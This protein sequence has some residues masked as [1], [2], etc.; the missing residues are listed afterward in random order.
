MGNGT[1][2]GIE[3]LMVSDY[4]FLISYLIK[5]QE[6]SGTG[7]QNIPER[8]GISKSDFGLILTTI[9]SVMQEEI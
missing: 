6:I 2:G 3:F 8:P 1:K 5:R 4:G 7:S 9:N